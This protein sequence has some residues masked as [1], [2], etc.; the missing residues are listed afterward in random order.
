MSAV[1]SG[2]SIGVL[3]PGELG[4]WTEKRFVGRTV[5]ETVT[6]GGNDVLRATSVGSASGL[7]RKIR[8]D[9]DSTPFLNW[10]WR[11]E[12]ALQGSDERTRAG[13]DFAARVYVVSNHP[14]LPWLGRAV[15][16]VWSGSQPV[17]RAW[18]NPRS[19]F[20]R[21][22]ALRS[23]NGDS[24]RWVGERRDV[25]A[26]FREFFGKDL[27]SVDAVAIMTDTDNAGGSAVAHYGEI[28]FTAE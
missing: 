17:G 22:M 13:D 21:Q 20:V 7:F 9:L 18:P 26:D 6:L 10:R 11:V 23:G 15:N 14:V 1:D 2:Q 28:R 16:Y 19:R 5:Y 12:A 4:P 24:R 8:D 3:Q 25:R 27:R